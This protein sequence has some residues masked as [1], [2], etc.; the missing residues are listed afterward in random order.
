MSTDMNAYVGWFSGPAWN[1]LVEALLH[2]LWIAMIIA[3]GLRAALGSMRRPGPRYVA[4]L[5][6]LGAVFLATMAVWPAAERPRHTSNPGDSTAATTSSAAAPVVSTPLRES[7]AQN[8]PQPDVRMRQS[9]GAL[10][11]AVA[12]AKPWLAILWCLGSM[13]MLLRCA[14]QVADADHLRRSC[15]PAADAALLGLLDEALAALGHVRKIE[16]LIADACSSPLVVGWLMPALI[17]PASLVTSLSQEQIRLILLHE[18]AHVRR[19]D[20]LANLLQMIVES[21]F[22]FNPG[23]W[24]ISRQ[25]R[26]EREACCDEIAVSAGGNRSGYARALLVVAEKALAAPSPAA[27]AFG[28][29]RRSGAFTRRV[30]R[31]LHP[32]RGCAVEPGLRA[33][34]GWFTAGC[35]LLALIG[36]GTRVTVGVILTPE[37]RMERTARIAAEHGLT[38][39]SDDANGAPQSF[40]PLYGVVQVADGGPLPG[41]V[42]IMVVSQSEHRSES[43]SFGTKPDGTFSQ[44]VRPG[45]I[46]VSAYAPNFAPCVSSVVTNP[47][48]QIRLV[49][50][51][52]RTISLEA[53]DEASGQALP[54]T[55]FHVQY[56]VPKSSSTQFPLNSFNADEHGVGL[57]L[58]ASDLPFTV[59]TELEGYVRTQARFEHLPR[60]DSL[61]VRVPRG[62]EFSGMVLD[63]SGNQ[64]I[65]GA[66]ILLLLEEGSAGSAFQWESPENPV[67]RADELG[68]FHINRFKRHTAYHLGVR[69]PGHEAVVVGPILAPKTNIIARLGSE[70]T[71]EGKVTGDLS[72]LRVEDGQPRLVCGF[73][74]QEN[75][76]RSFSIP[77]RIENGEAH[78][79]F[80]N[81]VAGTVRVDLNGRTNERFVDAP[82]V[83]W[84]IDAP[85]AASPSAPVP[86][87]KVIV[88]LLPYKGVMP[89]GSITITR[90]EPGTGS[91]VTYAGR[92]LALRDGS[93]EFEVPTGTFVEVAPSR[94]TLGFWFEPRTEHNVSPAADPLVLELPVIPAGII[95]ARARDSQ[96]EPMSDLSFSVQQLKPSPLLKNPA[97]T[98]DIGDSWSA[99]DGPRNYLSPPLPLGGTYLI[100]ACKKNGFAVSDPVVLTEEKPDA[101]VELRFP[102]GIPLRGRVTD[103]QGKPLPGIRIS[104]QISIASHGYQLASLTTDDT[105]VFLLEGATRGQGQGKYL[106]EVTPTSHFR[107][108]RVEVDMNRTPIEIRLEPGLRFSGTLGQAGSSAVIPDGRIRLVDTSGASPQVETKSDASGRFEFSNLRDSEYFLFVEGAR[109]VDQ[110]SSRIRP[111]AKPTRDHPRIDCEIGNGSGLKAVPAAAPSRPAGL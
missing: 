47:A 55:R 94:T 33:G 42:Q 31:V 7:S 100:T 26:I 96:G 51:K 2:S 87:R 75:H 53:R 67:A 108:A 65:R 46:V 3:V 13:F 32:D 24:W 50:D 12:R 84:I 44:K 37:Q 78:F 38:P 52:G 93:V 76:W 77:A 102:A 101:S 1:G 111:T 4:C 82:V 63:K 19:R 72:S 27:V 104:P 48:E 10:V 54:G 73:S 45:R 21:L 22:F 70:L 15:K 25:A 64:P 71:V 40:V 23:V 8:G 14:V 17:F 28:A 6:A 103:T 62:A 68:R 57:L 56:W 29:D 92:Q 43:A 95:Q 88:R 80:T 20:Y 39:V 83:D 60:E 9:H 30:M 58:H 110:Q 11:E 105:G 59:T 85:P 107:A 99:N 89:R 49:L 18:L 90:A 34:L 98:L 61:T 35:V 66:E 97:V 74:E 36:F 16:L 86:L 41:D 106:L 109:V 81:R 91:P 79:R 5:A 69:A